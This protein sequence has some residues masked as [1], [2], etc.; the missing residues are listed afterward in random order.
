[1]LRSG[2][3]DPTKNACFP[4]LSTPQKCALAT[5]IASV[6]LLIISA[7]AL[8]GI[9][10]SASAFEP[11]GSQVGDVGAFVMFGFAVFSLASLAVIS[12]CKNRDSSKTAFSTEQTVS[13]TKPAAAPV[14]AEVESEDELSPIEQAA[15]AGNKEQVYDLLVDDNAEGTLRGEALVRAAQHGHVKLVELLLQGTIP[16]DDLGEA[17]KYA[18]KSGSDKGLENYT[19]IVMK[20]LKNHVI[21]KEQLGEA[22]IIAATAAAKSFTPA[23]KEIIF[24]LL[25]NGPISS[26][27]RAQAVRLA[28]KASELAKIL[29]TTK[30]LLT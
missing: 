17:L 27:D 13:S 15:I 5:I 30:P 6:A 23:Y 4:K 24:A 8:H 3:V 10:A 21:S 20:L 19:D 11:F 12:C 25:Q 2:S 26:A 14:P 1:M 29:Q 18:L 16:E 7:L 22:V 9:Y 28:P